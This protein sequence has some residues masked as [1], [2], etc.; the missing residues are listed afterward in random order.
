M[1]EM[2]MDEVSHLGFNSCYFL[3]S[4][5]GSLTLSTGGSL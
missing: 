5:L 1:A 4:L 3:S 2:F